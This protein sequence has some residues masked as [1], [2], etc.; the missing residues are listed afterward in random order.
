MQL[1]YCSFGWLFNKFIKDRYRGWWMNY[2]YITAAAWDVGL[3]LMSIVLF[4]AVQLPTNKVMP[5][6]WGTTV[7]N[8]IDITGSGNVRKT[9]ADGETFGPRE[10]KW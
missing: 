10:W 9:V 4:F 6:W 2:N 7:I 8:T 3:A 5:D 1:A